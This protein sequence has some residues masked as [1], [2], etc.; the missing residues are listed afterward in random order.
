[1]L[2][3]YGTGAIMAVPAH[4]TRDFAF[5]RAFEL[6]IACVVE[7]TDGR[8]ED[9]AAWDDAFVAYEAELVNSANA[10]VSLNGLGVVEAKARITEWLTEKGIGEGTVNFR[11]RDWLFSRQRYW[12]EPF[13]IVYDEDGVMHALP[14]SMLPVEVPEVDDY[15]PRTF[16]ADDAKS[17]PETPLSRNAAWVNVD[18]DLGDGRGTRR[19]RRETNT[20]PNWAGS[21]WYELRYVDPDDEVAVVDPVN[22]RYWMGPDEHKRAGGVDLYV[23]GA[24][25]AVLHLLYSRFWH[26]VLFDLGYVSSKEP[27]HKLFNQGM[28]TADVYRDARGFPVP[29]AEVEERDGRYYWQ[30]DPVSR[31]AGKMG[32]SLKNA[33]AP[34][35]FCD[36]YGADTLR[37]YEMSMGPLDVSKPWDTKAVAGS[38]RFLQRVWRNIVDEETGRVR[39][40]EVAPDTETLRAAHQAVAGV[41]EDVAAL[42][43][44]TAIAKLI[45]LNNHLTKLDAVPRQTAEMLVLALAPFAPHV[46][47]E[48]WDKLGHA[49]SLVHADFPVA[50]PRYLVADEVTCVVQVQGKVRDKIQV[51]PDITEEALRELAL[52]SEGAR[53]ALDGRGVRTVIVRAPKLVNIVV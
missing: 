52:A 51:P 32:K 27:F 23:G 39:V 50:D 7:P 40:S 28:I 48:L 18:L 21:C 10:E 29:A 17:T 9:T 12:G 37:V 3:G 20:M 25:H 2:M 22:E 5:A 33:I 6:P 35:E 13:P 30:G 47:E 31:E 44:N 4:D 11:L 14:D 53:R 42:R 19:Y 41:H 1:V 46:A 43:F 34:D 16:D 45:V 38:V 24:E 8:G 15:S 36:T 26:K 49:D